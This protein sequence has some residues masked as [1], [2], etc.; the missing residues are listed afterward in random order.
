M[1][2]P[3]ATA[4]AERLVSWLTPVCERVAVAGSVRRQRPAPNDIDL[5]AIPKRIEERDLFGAVAARKNAA[6]VEIQARAKAE[7]WVITKAGAE[8]VQFVA[9]GVQ[10]DVWWTEPQFWGT[11]LLCRTGSVQHNIWLAEYAQ[12]RGGK[13][14]PHAGLYLGNHRVS[15]TEEEIYAALGM[16]PIPPER[17]EANQLPFAGLLR[18][19]R[20][21]AA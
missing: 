17:R 12:A 20:G 2:L 10:V 1:N 21:P 11:V 4:C 18:G 6:W 9:R 13:W 15:L 14:H 3:F 5:V 16:A 8:M 19:A 7:D